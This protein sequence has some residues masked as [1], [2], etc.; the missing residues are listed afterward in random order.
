VLLSQGATQALAPD[1]PPL[2][3]HSVV[4]FPSPL[5]ELA[6]RLS[7]HEDGGGEALLLAARVVRGARAPWSLAAG[8]GCQQPSRQRRYYLTPA[9]SGSYGELEFVRRRPDLGALGRFP[10]TALAV[11]VRALGGRRICKRLTRLGPHPSPRV[12]GPS[13]RDSAEARAVAGWREGVPLPRRGMRRRRCLARAW[14][15]QPRASL[16]LC[17]YHGVG[18]DDGCWGRGGFDRC[19]CWRMGGDI[20]V[21]NGSR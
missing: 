18:V 11:H 15:W 14:Q 7:A 19:L 9:T 20:D 5:L 4:P 3:P 1:S 2:P 12:S 13:P 16:F 21:G 17:S 8:G 10:V 6:A